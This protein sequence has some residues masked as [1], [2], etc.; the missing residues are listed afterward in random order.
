[1]FANFRSELILIITTMLAAAGWVFSK[2]AIEGLPPF[3]FIGLRFVTAS[4]ILAPFCFSA[5]KQATRQDCFKA[6][7]VGL[8]LGGSIFCWIYAISI[9]PTLGEGAF[10]MSLSMLFVPLLAWPLFGLKPN[11]AFWLSLPVAVLGLFLLSWNGAWHIAPNQL[12]FLIAAFGLALHFNFNSQCSAKLPPML[13]TTL[14]L[15]TAGMVGLLLSFFLEAW[16]QTISLG[17]WKWFTLSVLLATSLRYLMQTIG[18][19]KAHPANAALLMLLEPVWTLLL[20]VWFYHESL[21]F[22]KIVGCSLLLAALLLYR[23][24]WIQR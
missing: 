22:N 18:Q 14:Q 11:R 21:P 15:F 10:I 23:I 9:S 17:T 19:K 3:G 24:P 7:G 12:W 13:L 4:C 6:M 8:F 16:P 1:M 2:Q 20:S 5:F